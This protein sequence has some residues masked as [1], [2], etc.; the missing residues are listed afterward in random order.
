MTKVL[1]DSKDAELATGGKNTC[2]WVAYGISIDTRTLKKGD[3][4]I[5][6]NDNRD[7]HD[8]VSKA[9]KN[10]AVAAIVTR[11]PVDVCDKKPLLIVPDVTSALNALAAF[12]RKRCQAKVIAITGSVGKTSS[13]DMLETVLLTFG[14]VSKAEKSFNN[15]LGV[16][17]TLAS[18]PIDTNYLIVEI[19][20]SNKKEI[21][22]LS[23]LVRPDIALITNVSEAHLAAFNNVDEIAREKS[24]ICAGLVKEGHCIVS[25]DSDSYSKLL[26]FIN[27]FGIKVV[28]YGEKSP[29]DYRLIKTAILNNK[30]CAQ[31]LLRNG[32][33][34]FFKV[35]SPG[36]HHAQNALG[37][38]AVLELLGLDAT[39]GILGLSNWVPTS[40]RGVITSVTCGKQ[41]LPRTFTIIDETYNANPCSMI[42]AIN[43][44][45]HFDPRSEFT[46][47]NRR[48][49]R[50]A[51]LGDMLELGSQENK[52]HAELVKK[53]VLDDIDLI[54]CVGLRMKFFYENLPETKRGKWTKSVMELS[55]TVKE[56]IKDE[57][58]VMLKA[59]NGVG[60][61][62]LLKELKAMGLPN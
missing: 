8:F 24:D 30:T 10:G 51:I 58:V 50:V 22:P 5:A 11:I 33:E 59:S 14:K 41:Y 3:I 20:M 4:F 31:A 40:G 52:K 54:H 38:I 32:E 12:A 17:L 55:K 2:E 21:Y 19:G 57:D 26:S 16:P 60:L 27:G 61:N 43:V 39:K 53:M 42:S 37:V 25:K 9:F 35:N 1:W 49:R 45:A 7:G 44:L 56:L 23:V 48:F 15:H 36:S 29:A 18:A 34:C 47:Q 28:S 46:Q 13:K 6:I 62:R